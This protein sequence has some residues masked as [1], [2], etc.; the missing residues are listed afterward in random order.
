MV[1]VTVEN[2]MLA[3]KFY[4]QLVML[5]FKAICLYMLL[6]FSYMKVIE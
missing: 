2:T 1:M 3:H 4:R 5:S 6:H